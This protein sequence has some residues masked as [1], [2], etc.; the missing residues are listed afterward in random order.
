[1]GGGCDQH[2]VLRYLG[3]AFAWRGATRE[4]LQRHDGQH[5]QHTELRHVARQGG[6]EDAHRRGGEQTERRAS[7]EQCNGTLDWNAQD[8]AT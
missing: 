3:H 2:D 4:H 8:A 1:M 7:E 5:H 6:E